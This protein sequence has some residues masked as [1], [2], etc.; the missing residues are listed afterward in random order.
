MNDHISIKGARTHNLKNVNI[1]IPRNQ[2][3]VITGKSG[4]GKSSLA[5][6]TLYAEGQR[7]YV[8]SLSTYARQFLSMM[9]KPDVDHISGLSPAISIEQ[10]SISHNPRSTVGTTTEIYDYLR[11]LFAR[12]GSASCPI[13]LTPLKAQAISQMVEHILQLNPEERF[14][15]LAPVVQDRKGE[16]IQLIENLKRQGFIR[17]R[18]DGIVY[19]I[20]NLPPI[21]KKTKHTLQ[22]V[23]DRFKV[24][25]E[26]RQRLA[27]S[28]E[29]A[30]SLTD[31]IAQLLS[32]D[33]DTQEAITFSRKYACPSCGF[34]IQ[35]LEPKMFSFN[36]PSGAC[37]TCDGLGMQRSM[38]GELLIIDPKLSPKQGA[39]IGWGPDNKYYWQLLSSVL[40]HFNINP[41]TPWENISPAAQNMILNGSGNQSIEISY[42]DIK[43]QPI[44]RLKRFEG[45]LPTMYRRYM[46]TDSESIKTELSRFISYHPCHACGGSRLSEIA[47]CV[48]V[49]GYQIQEI[50]AMT[51]GHA[52]AFFNRAQFDHQK[53]QVAER[54]LKEIQDRLHFLISVGLDYLSLDRASETLS[55]GESQRIRLASQIGSG[56]VGVMYVLDEPSIGLHQRDN[57]RLIDTLKH[58]KNLGNTVIVVEHDEDTILQADHIID[59]GPGAGIHGGNVIAQGTAQDLINT[60]DS[61]TG[62]YLSGEKFLSTDSQRPPKET[63]FI[64][65]QG[66]CGN[67]LKQACAAFPIGY[68]TCVTG[69][70]GSGKSTLINNTLLPMANNQLNRKFKIKSAPCIKI[71]NLEHF[72][73][74]ID[75]DQNPI[76]R[77]PRSN[78][79]TYT[80]L[81]TPIREL[82]AQTQE[83]RARGY[84]PGRFS[85]NVRGGRCEACQGDGLI[86]VEMHF[87]S[88]VYVTCDLC[89]GQ[90]YNQETLGIHFKGKNIAQVLA[91]TIEEGLTFFENIPSI[92][93]KLQTLYDVG[94]NY[95]Q[96]GQSATTLS[97][98]EAQR[99]K[100]AKE[101]A[102]RQTGKTLYI[103]DEPTSGLHFDDVRALM[104]VITKLRDHGNTIV[105]IEHHLDVI[106]MADWIVDMGPEGGNQGGEVI[107]Q[108]T[109]HDIQACQQSHTGHFLKKHLEIERQKLSRYRP[110]T[111]DIGNN[112]RD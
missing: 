34:A 102:K 18:L 88:D 6:D 68:F 13:H 14:M 48:R 35:E 94:L 71:S 82:F 51:I 32:M 91:L 38:D 24:K 108:G 111:L 70:S 43:G 62:Q 56:L 83:A 11:L 101:L 74:V 33:N 110:K 58:L 90:R 50:T 105:V 54:I 28:L 96:L 106:K 8:E 77:T 46:E 26:I 109:T 89:H 41:N 29:L 39:I 75:I 42:N 57:Q 40:S 49:D 81:F 10:K 21:D 84:N 2:L 79:A 95:I 61:L 86:R 17:L 5:F 53:I 87:L 25:A 16:H 47:R 19:E 12:T 72:D 15:I 112:C 4:S 31:G 92:A 64:E 85:F 69:V 36:N 7:R 97:G 44:S 63:L 80:G 52:Q 107:F 9:E 45:V 78:P 55:G 65:I 23:I 66:A 20:D 93:S 37:Q 3:V 99:I 30:T 98:G 73:K 59:I 76:G 100:L 104:E 22:V 103:L 60:P 1:D 27:E 67:N